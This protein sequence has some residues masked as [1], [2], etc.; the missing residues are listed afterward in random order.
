MTCPRRDSPNKNAFGS[1]HRVERKPLFSNDRF[2]RHG[3]RIKGRDTKTRSILMRTKHGK[4][5]VMR[6]IGDRQ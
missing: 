3:C 5:I 2:Q 1:V 6:T 4:G